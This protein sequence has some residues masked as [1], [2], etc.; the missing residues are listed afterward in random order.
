MA[1]NIPE[2]TDPLVVPGGPLAAVAVLA[3]GA[4]EGLRAVVHPQQ[5][6]PVDGLVQCTYRPVDGIIYLKMDLYACFVFSEAA[7]NFSDIL[8][9]MNLG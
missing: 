4:A 1:E 7:T 6:L 8:I 3:P 2:R 5:V 9:P